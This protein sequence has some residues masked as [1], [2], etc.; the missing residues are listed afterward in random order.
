MN[1]MRNLKA[2]IFKEFFTYFK[3]PIAYIFIT[4]FLFV[5]N[6][7]FFQDFFLRGEINIRPYFDLLPLMLL[8]LT[9][10]ISMRLW[11]EEKSQ[12]TEEVLLT[13]PIS[14][15]EVVL[16]KFFGSVLFLI[17]C[18]IFS[19]TVPITLFFLGRFDYGTLL[20]GYIGLIL[21]AS[22]YLSLGLFISTLGSS[23]IVAFIGTLTACFFFFIISSEFIL[24]T[25]PKFLVPIFQFLGTGFHFANFSRGLID[26]RDITYFL[27]LIFFFLLLTKNSIEKRLWK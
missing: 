15:W 6:W 22:L 25:S 19:L 14:D 8:L 1:V 16:G 13:L 4:I 17:F 11:S 23:Q 5:T 18:L 12:K 20:T 21:L 3:L 24:M 9:P 2:L 7:L 27:S 26:T 10:A